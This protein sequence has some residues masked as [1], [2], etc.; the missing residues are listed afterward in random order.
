MGNV[1]PKLETHV[2]DLDARE[3]FILVISR[4]IVA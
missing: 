4:A 1:R 2:T 3:Y